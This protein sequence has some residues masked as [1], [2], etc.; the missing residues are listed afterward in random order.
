VSSQENLVESPLRAAAAASATQGLIFQW[1]PWSLKCS[2]ESYMGRV[3]AWLEL[4][5]VSAHP[6]TEA[7]SDIVYIL[8]IINYIMGN[9][10]SMKDDPGDSIEAS[11]DSYFDNYSNYT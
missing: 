1:R 2:S 10:S 6:L 7:K 5:Q 4:G 3:A 8:I 9:C 11:N